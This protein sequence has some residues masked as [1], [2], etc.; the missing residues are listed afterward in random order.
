MNTK[1]KYLLS[2]MSV[3]YDHWSTDRARTVTF[4][5]AR[6]LKNDEKIRYYVTDS[7]CVDTVWL[8]SEYHIASAFVAKRMGVYYT[9]VAWH[10]KTRKVGALQVKTFAGWPNA[11]TADWL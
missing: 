9:A 6:N 10:W 4:W 11:L 5:Q 2:R 1:R 3:E 7:R 8:F